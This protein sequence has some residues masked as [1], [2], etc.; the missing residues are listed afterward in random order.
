MAAHRSWGGRTL[1]APA[2]V[3]TVCQRRTL[4]PCTA[5]EVLNRPRKP[6]LSRGRYVLCCAISN[7][8]R[9][10]G[11]ALGKT[12]AQ[13][14]ELTAGRRDRYWLLQGTE[15]AFRRPMGAQLLV[16]CARAVRTKRKLLGA[17]TPHQSLAGTSRSWLRNHTAPLLS[18]LLARGLWRDHSC[19]RRGGC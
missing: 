8:L 12:T 13:A 19:V 18:V 9:A 15:Y 1:F 11:L 5:G 7:L 4:T 3:T 6:P 10:E 14:T 2:V 17:C 16:R